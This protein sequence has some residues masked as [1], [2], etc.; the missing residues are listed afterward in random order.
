MLWKSA[1]DFPQELIF[2]VNYLG[3]WMPT[4]TLNF[5]SNSI[6]VI[7]QYYNFL[8]LGKEGYYNIMHNCLSNAQYLASLLEKLGVFTLINKG[9]KFPIVAIKLKSSIQNYSV[10]NLSHKLRERGWVISAYTLPPH[11]EDIAI[12]RIVVKENFSRDMADILYEDIQKAIHELQ[13]GARRQKLNA[14]SKGKHHPIC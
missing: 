4:Y 7:A 10:F 1:K 14:P 12:M 11:A 2:N 6:N 9:K 3:D 8:R 5:S 13:K